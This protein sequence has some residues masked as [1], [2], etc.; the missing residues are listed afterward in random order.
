MCHWMLASPRRRRP[1][2]VRDLLR[3]RRWFACAGLLCCLQAGVAAQLDVVR[4]EWH[5]S[6]AWK[7]EGCDMVCYQLGLWCTEGCWPATRDGLVRALEQPAVSGVCWLVEEGAAQAWHPA[8]DPENSMCYQDPGNTADGETHRC[9]IQPSTP[10]SSS[11]LERYIRRICPCVNSTHALFDSPYLDC[12]L[13]AHS[14]A[15]VAEPQVVPAVPT[16]MPT[17]VL[18]GPPGSA[19]MPPST[20][21]PTPPPSSAQ[22]SHSLSSCTRLCVDGFGG[23]DTYFNDEY[24]REDDN[25]HFRNWKQ[26]YT[27]IQVLENR[28]Q[29]LEVLSPT[30]NRSIAYGTL[31]VSS[32]DILPPSDYFIT[33]TS[34]YPAQFWCCPDGYDWLSASGVPVYGEDDSDGFSDDLKAILSG[35]GIALVLA[36]A[37][38]LGVFFLM[39]S[40]QGRAFWQGSFSRSPD[41]RRSLKLESEESTVSIKEKV[42]DLNL[43]AVE[44]VSQATGAKNIGRIAWD[45]PA[46]PLQPPPLGS[47]GAQSKPMRQS[48]FAEPDD[49]GAAGVAAVLGRTA[50]SHIAKDTYEGPVK[51]WWHEEEGSD[52]E[53]RFWDGTEVRV[54]GLTSQPTW[55]GAVGIIAG[56]DESRGVYAVEMDDGRVKS[57]RANNLEL[58][59][60]PPHDPTATRRGSAQHSSPQ[61]QIQHASYRQ[62][63]G[64]PQTSASVTQPPWHSP[65]PSS[66]GSPGSSQP[67]S[68]RG[69]TSSRSIGPLRKEP[70]PVP[71]PPQ[72]LGTDDKSS[73]RA[74]HVRRETTPTSVGRNLNGAN[75]T[76]FDTERGEL[77]TVEGSAMTTSRAS[78]FG[79]SASSKA[80]APSPGPPLQSPGANQN[81]RMGSTSGSLR[82]WPRTP[83][84]GGPGS[85]AEQDLF[86]RLD[87]VGKSIEQ[88]RH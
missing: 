16:P 23:V 24:F 74:G 55:N 19:T 17:L 35:I 50:V 12:G 1:E 78:G 61:Q 51:P 57:V 39:Q 47:F 70:P 8:K 4:V 85:T 20:P 49:R 38:A 88:R 15:P 36:A 67:P 53:E 72:S 52:E 59:S 41:E 40:R 66:R 32:A 13:G 44:M 71:P 30:S 9:P 82:S 63:W 26:G 33:S 60:R 68:S 86:A 10:S 27:G 2:T 81:S 62:A 73:Y 58:A 80:S 79:A 18:T 83:T 25:G 6:N 48:A 21:P 3:P 28:W 7:D 43:P 11:L 84:R 77:V 69:L 56:Y 5:I 37:F 64:A 75:I 65:A 29:F 87:T 34:G 54:V 76:Y 14:I 46:Q 22:N 42:P 45:Q 31:V